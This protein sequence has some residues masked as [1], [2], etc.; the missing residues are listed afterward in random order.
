[1]LVGPS[2]TFEQTL[3]LSQLSSIIQPPEVL[4]LLCEILA[5]YQGVPLVCNNLRGGSVEL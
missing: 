5:L 2:H 4:G 1:M 3:V